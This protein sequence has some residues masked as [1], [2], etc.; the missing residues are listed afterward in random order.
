MSELQLFGTIGAKKMKVELDS[1]LVVYFITL[2][3]YIRR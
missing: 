1:F 2:Y 3:A